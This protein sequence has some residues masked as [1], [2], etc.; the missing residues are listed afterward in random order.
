MKMSVREARSNFA[1]ALDLADKGETKTITKNGKPIAELGP[2]KP[3]KKKGFDWD[4]AEQ[5]RKEN[6]LSP[7]DGPPLDEKWL[8]EYN[9]PAKN[10]ALLGLGDDWQPDLA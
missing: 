10:R 4:R 8:E 2:P 5:W 1:H 7:Y 6:G 9:D 3:V